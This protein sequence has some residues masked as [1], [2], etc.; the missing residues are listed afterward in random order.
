MNEMTL[1]AQNAH[2]TPL[3][4]VHTWVRAWGPVLLLMALI[5]AASAQPKTAAPADADGVYFSGVMPIFIEATW[6]ALVKKSAHV[7]GYA[8]L[9]ALILRALLRE[10]NAPREA[11][12]M[13]LLLALTYAMTDELHQAFVAGRHASVLDIGF[14]Y[15]GAVSASLIGRRVAARA[16]GWLPLS[17]RGSGAE[18]SQYN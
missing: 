7:I 11:A 16:R 13:A 15:V 8:L 5:F 17:A 6:D 1:R 3:H 14:D 12:Y 4:R 2:Q 10:G 18:R 9:A